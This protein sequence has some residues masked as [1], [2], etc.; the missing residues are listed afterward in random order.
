[1]FKNALMRKCHIIT[2]LRSSID[3]CKGLQQEQLPLYDNLTK[4]L[5]PEEQQVVQAAVHQADLLAA[6]ALNAEQQQT[7]GDAIAS[8]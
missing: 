5:N 3:I 1:M 4:N 8:Q 2:S 6:Q 7:N